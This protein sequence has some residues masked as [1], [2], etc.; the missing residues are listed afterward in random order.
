MKE[1]TVSR[2]NLYK[3]YEVEELLANEAVV[4]ITYHGE[5]RFMLTLTPIEPLRT[6]AFSGFHR[7][8]FHLLHAKLSEAPGYRA[9]RVICENEFT[10]Y[11][12]LLNQ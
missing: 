6:L 10:F 1:I 8:S 4:F 3:Q 11:A 7:V 2:F 9:F 5:Q 12:E